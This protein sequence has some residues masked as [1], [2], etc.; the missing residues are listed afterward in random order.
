MQFITSLRLLLLSSSS[1]NTLL[2]VVGRA[3][4]NWE[5]WAGGRVAAC[6][7]DTQKGHAK[8]CNEARQMGPGKAQRHA[9]EQAT[10]K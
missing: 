6:T 1:S 10:L 8:H 3:R 9:S 7:Q 2:R 5:G 4:P